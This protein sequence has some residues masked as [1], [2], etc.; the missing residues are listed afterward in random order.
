MIVSDFLH[1]KKVAREK[2][3]S[4]AHEEFLKA[5]GDPRR[6]NRYLSSAVVALAVLA[7]GLGALLYSEMNRQRERIVIRI[8]DVGRAEAV[9]FSTLNFKLQPNECK[10]FLAQ[11]IVDYYQ[12]KRSTMLEDIKRS[13]MFLS[14]ELAAARMGENRRTK[15]I[16]R[17]LNGADEE[18]DIAIDNIVLSELGSSPYHAQID[19]VKIYKDRSGVESHRE[20][21]IVGVS[22]TSASTV[23]NADILVNP[24]GFT[25]LSIREDQAF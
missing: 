13:T 18:I 1:G 14:S 10:Y 16:E 5:M 9:G 4:D 24:I 2:N 7:M 3:I 12:K 15:D 20:K 22:F 8:N 25:V 6:L 17:F 19:M 11:F 21:Y 23:H